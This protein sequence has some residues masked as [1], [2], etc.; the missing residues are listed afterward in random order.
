MSNCEFDW[1]ARAAGKKGYSGCSFSRAGNE[2]RTRDLNLGKV[3]LTTELFPLSE[4][5]L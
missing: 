5:G 4:V 2:I 3:A 1:A